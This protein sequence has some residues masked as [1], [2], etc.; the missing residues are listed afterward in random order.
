MDHVDWKSFRQR[1]KFH[2]PY[3]NDETL[4]LQESHGITRCCLSSNFEFIFVNGNG[5]LHLHPSFIIMKRTTLPQIAFQ[6]HYIFKSLLFLCIKWALMWWDEM[7]SHCTF[8]TLAW[9]SLIGLHEMRV[10]LSCNANR[11]V[12]S[13]PVCMSSERK[14]VLIRLIKITSITHRAKAKQRGRDVKTSKIN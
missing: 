4:L 6:Q 11:V 8:C 9:Q 13:S 12:F 1:K 14:G 5:N 10:D 2:R 3:C 7:S